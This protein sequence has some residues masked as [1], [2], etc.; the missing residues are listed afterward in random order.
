MVAEHILINWLTGHEGAHSIHIL[1]Y[2]YE[3]KLE[4]A[5]S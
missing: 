5:E 2:F 1:C 3:Q 4:R